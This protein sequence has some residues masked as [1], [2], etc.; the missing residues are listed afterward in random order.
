M[1]QLLF[2]IHSVN[3]VTRRTSCAPFFGHM[4]ES[5]VR[6][7]SDAGFRPFG[8]KVER[9]GQHFI[10]A[11]KSSKFIRRSP[12][13]VSTMRRTS[14]RSPVLNRVFHQYVVVDDDEFLSSGKKAEESD[15][16]FISAPK[17]SR[18]I[19]RLP[20]TVFPII[21]EETA[22]I[23]L[24]RLNRIFGRRVVSHDPRFR[25]SGEK[26]EASGQ[27]LIPIEE[28]N[29]ELWPIISTTTPVP[30]SSRFIRRSPSVLNHPDFEPF[31]EA[32]QCNK[33]PPA[34]EKL[35]DKDDAS[36]NTAKS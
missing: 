28:E 22:S 1:L 35:E 7:F 21:I 25:S 33:N 3:C 15:Q 10:P 34:Y 29:Q 16:H 30:K 2:H 27:P 14:N 12:S 23:P 17:S 24:P 19:R 11:P 26:I 8:K 9:L 18:F 20:S 4:T 6:L 32:S 36:A 31:V 13:T 5:S